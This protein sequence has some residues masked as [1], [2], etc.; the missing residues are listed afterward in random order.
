MKPK[1][2]VEP[3][4][5]QGELESQHM[6]VTDQGDS[7]HIDIDNNE[8]YI[9]SAF[10]DRD[11]AEHLYEWLGVWLD[12]PS[13]AAPLSTHAR[14]MLETLNQENSYLKLP[15][16]DSD[17]HLINKGEH[18]AFVDTAWVQRKLIEPGYIMRL[19][20]TGNKNTKVYVL[21]AKGEQ[22]LEEAS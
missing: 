6:K 4:S 21:S 16:S 11:K 8:A 5:V 18:E 2:I 22:V 10:L 14:L 19:E 9:H 1:L 15:L 7:V 13:P 12:K 3:L 20:T 17:F